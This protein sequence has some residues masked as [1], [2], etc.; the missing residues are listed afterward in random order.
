[1]LIYILDTEENQFIIANDPNAWGTDK[2]NN[3]LYEEQNINYTSF[4]LIHSI[5]TLE[6][7]FDDR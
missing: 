7:S 2:Q 3:I 1:M 6:M 5:Y 4:S